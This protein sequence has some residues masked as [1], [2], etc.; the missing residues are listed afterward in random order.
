VSEQ[1]PARKGCEAG[2]RP[3]SNNLVWRQQERKMALWGGIAGDVQSC[4]TR[5][6]SVAGCRS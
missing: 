3:S 5:L 1:S 4:G 2:E 6:A